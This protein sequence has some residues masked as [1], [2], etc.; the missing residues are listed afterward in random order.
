MLHIRRISRPAFLKSP[1]YA[2]IVE[3]LRHFH[4]EGGARKKQ[5]RFSPQRALGKFYSEA[6][7]AAA[8]L[9]R[10]KCAYTEVPLK[11]PKEGQ[12]AFHRP[13]ADAVGLDGESDPA[14][15]WWLIP[16]WSNW[17]YAS[18]SVI[19]V[20]GTQF[21]VVGRR[22]KLPSGDK[23]PSHSND[24]GILLD[25]CRDELPWYLSFTSD[26]LVKR[27]IHPSHL[28]RAKYDTESRGAHTIRILDL[29]NSRL[30]KLRSDTIAEVEAVLQD[31]PV[32]ASNEKVATLCHQNLPFAG[33]RRQL[34]A[35]WIVKL[36]INSQGH[37]DNLHEL[38]SRLKC[39]IAAELFAEPTELPTHFLDTIEPVRVYI[40]KRFP[41]IL[42]ESFI[43]NRPTTV[44]AGHRATDG[45]D[46]NEAITEE[47]ARQQAEVVVSRSARIVEIQI[48]NFKAI[49][50]IT[51]A[52]STDTVTLTSRYGDTNGVDIDSARW[53]VLL[54]ENGSGK[55]CILEAVGLA[56]SGEHLPQVLEDSRIEWRR[57]HRR[58]TE[59]ERQQQTPV[60]EGRIRLRLTGDIVIELQFDHSG[61]RWASPTPQMQAFIRGY[62]ATRLLQGSTSPERRCHGTVSVANLYDPRAPVIDAKDWLL[63]LDDGD[64][65]V[66][67]I[68]ISELLRPDRPTRMLTSDSTN[69]LIVRDVSAGEVFVDGDPLDVVSDG[70]RAVIAIASDIMA[71]LGAGLSDMHHARGI[72]LID[73]I[74]AHLHPKWRMTITDKLR[75]ALPNLQFIVSTHEPLCLRGLHENEVV[76]VRKT[77]EHGVMLDEIERS[78]SDYRVDQ[79]LTSEFFGLD[80]TIDPDLERRFQA[81]YQLL[82]IPEDQR[83]DSQQAE[84]QKLR[85]QLRSES[86]PVLGHTRRD[87]L[88]YEA[89]DDFLKDA[90][91]LE[92][93]ERKERR[94]E[95]LQEIVDIWQSRKAL[96]AQQSPNPT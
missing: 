87:Q 51:L 50:D 19:S 55:S 89:I 32:T 44:P 63:S 24:R 88:V 16:A 12:L 79:L 34:V 54:G 21:P 83:D 33:L 86:N 69:T 41:E 74:G 76:R 36:G 40:E 35:R 23:L 80:T 56:L 95:V 71:G 1:E 58:P 5:R 73:E 94:K 46:E 7:E 47:L 18:R 60:P 20:K 67:A 85:F 61:Y 13:P 96:S 49:R 91:N 15:Y 57:I 22:S 45:H 70:Y 11:S 43:Y 59:Y 64:F 26:G 31:M 3:R 84:L 27:R 30:V 9:F 90:E 6:T 72:V 68:A 4:A 25:P 52:L 62:G 75:R 28:E 17:Y 78:P 2:S 37:I 92:P 8:N 29:N 77:S 66:A 39:E 14:H 48:Q 65:N 82:A 10:N 93:Q 53:K 81:Y 42:S 38:V